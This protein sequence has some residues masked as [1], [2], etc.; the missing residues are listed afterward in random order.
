ME[1]I[2]S[3]EASVN[4]KERVERRRSMWVSVGVDLPGGRTLCMTRVDGM[5]STGSMQKTVL[6]A[7]ERPASQT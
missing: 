4:S 5:A 1:V 2:A 6:A 3:G 7:A